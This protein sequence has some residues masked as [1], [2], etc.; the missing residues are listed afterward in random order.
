ME[1]YADQEDEDEVREDPESLSLST[2]EKQ[3]L[4]RVKEEFLTFERDGLGVTSRAGRRSLG[5][6]ES[7]VSDV[8]GEAKG[9]RR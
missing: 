6:Q 3:A 4:E 8:L 9:C 1:H 7:S 2:D 5:V